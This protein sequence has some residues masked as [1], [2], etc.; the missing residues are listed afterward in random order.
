MP[1]QTVSRDSLIHFFSGAVTHSQ[2]QTAG[3][4]KATVPH[5]LFFVQKKKKE[6]KERKEE[7]M[8]ETNDTLEQKKRKENLL[9]LKVTNHIGQETFVFIHEIGL[10]NMRP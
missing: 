9:F 1:G 5:Y 8:Q 3:A 4:E 2:T 6:K 7:R 10:Y